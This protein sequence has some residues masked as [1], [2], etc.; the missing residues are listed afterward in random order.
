MKKLADPSAFYTYMRKTAF[1]GP[2]ISDSEL[3]GCESD[4]M[5]CGQADWPLSWVAYAMATDYHE[6]AGTMRPIKEYGSY[7]YFEHMYGPKG[8]NPTRAKSMGN[9]TPGDGAKYCGRGR[10]QLTWAKNYA[11]VGEKLR[12]PL[13]YNPDLALDPKIASEIMVQGMQEGWFTGK[14]MRHFLPSARPATV[15]E[16]IA[17]RAIINGKDKASRIASYAM[18]FQK[19]L[20]LGKYQ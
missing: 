4:L 2:T 12:I 16:F 14:A 8:K 15:E 10:V 7:S 3:S 19:G 9:T 17:A 5:A 1:M 11:K 13:Y 6:T 20:I 18:D